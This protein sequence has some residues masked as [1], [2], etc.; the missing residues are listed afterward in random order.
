MCFNIW[1]CS[2]DRVLFNSDEMRLGQCDTTKTHLCFESRFESGNLRKA[3]QVS[4]S[5]SCVLPAGTTCWEA[6]RGLVDQMHVAGFWR[7]LL[8]HRVNL[9]LKFWSMKVFEF[10]NIRPVSSQDKFICN[11]IFK[12]GPEQHI[13][14]Y[15][16]QNILTCLLP[17][18]QER[19]NSGLR[20]SHALCMCV[21][22][23]EQAHAHAHML[24]PIICTLAQTCFQLFSHYTALMK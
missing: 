1:C 21:C 7:L 11:R 17:F 19:K 23:R 5:T 10:C 22:M 15:H 24:D 16:K 2:F 14:S 13:L 12:S 3:L 4:Q 6:G 20:T 18:L 9:L 8:H